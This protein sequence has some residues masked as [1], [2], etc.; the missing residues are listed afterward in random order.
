MNFFETLSSTFGERKVKQNE[1]MALHTTIKT[2]G[3]ASYYV[4]VDSVQD[5]IKIVQL[6]QQQSIPYL[7]VGGGSNIVLSDRGFHGLVI[8][9]NCRK[10]EMVSMSGK[11]VNQHIDVSQAFLFAEAGAIINQIVRYS[12][13]HS[14]GGLETCLGLPGTVGGAVCV[15]A[16]YPKENVRIGNSVWKVKV[17]KSNGEIVDID[18]DACQFDQNSSIFQ[19]STDVIL[20]VIFRLAP[21]DKSMLWER[22]TAAVTYRSE[23]QPKGIHGCTYRNVLVRKDAVSEVMEPKELSALLTKADLL[24]EQYGGAGLATINPHYILNNGNAATADIMHL[25]QNITDKVYNTTSITIDYCVKQ[26]GEST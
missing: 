9:N 5:L 11:I 8:K 15:N 7:I 23:T 4:D 24:N 3:N 20:S 21:Q 13:E 17:L 25:V 16:N 19:N 2:G 6:A 18:A 14:L 12:L 1:S 22:A 10:F 26:K